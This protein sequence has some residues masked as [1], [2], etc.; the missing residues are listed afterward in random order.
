MSFLDINVRWGADESQ[1][2]NLYNKIASKSI[3]YFNYTERTNKIY[4]YKTSKLKG[5]I[6]PLRTTMTNSS[7]KK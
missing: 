3:H 6:N 1:H 4:L 2:Q 5:T 7:H